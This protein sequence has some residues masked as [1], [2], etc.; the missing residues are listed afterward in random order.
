M[1]FLKTIHF[2]QSDMHVFPKPAES[3]EWAVSGG[4]SFSD[5]DEE[6]LQ[7]KWKQAFSN[8]FFSI[9]SFG[10]ATFTQ[11]VFMELDELH[12]LTEALAQYFVQRF[13][14]P[15]VDEARPVAAAEIDFV[16]K[17]CEDV[18]INSVFTVRRFFD[19]AGEIREE[20]R[21]VDAPGEKPHARV[22]DVV[23]DE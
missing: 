11:V 8:G 2:D 5:M 13:G 4:F 9:E 6:D 10:H 20:F 23:E 19:D 22:W 21:I 15:S 3:D 16:M 14:A 17:L 7:G 12:A 18:P 1:K